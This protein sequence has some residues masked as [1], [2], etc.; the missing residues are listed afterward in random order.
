MPHAKEDKR[1]LC[2]FFQVFGLH[3]Y[4]PAAVMPSLR[5]ILITV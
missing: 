5:M 1:S 3:H 4:V 2:L